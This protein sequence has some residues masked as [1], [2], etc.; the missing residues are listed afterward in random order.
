MAFFI[1]CEWVAN[2]A[3]FGVFTAAAGTILVVAPGREFKV[4]AT[5]DMEEEISASPAVSNGVLYLRTFDAL[6]AIGE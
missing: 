3:V 1:G 6:Y 5:N 2:Q 4:L